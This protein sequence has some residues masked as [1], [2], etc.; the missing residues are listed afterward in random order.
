MLLIEQ[1]GLQI[2]VFLITCA[3]SLLQHAIIKPFKDDMLNFFYVFNDFMLIILGII[4]IQFLDNK[5]P[6]T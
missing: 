6:E 1:P 5:L 2:V 4:M 3:A